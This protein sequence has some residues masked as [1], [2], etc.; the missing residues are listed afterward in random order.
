LRNGPAR[1]RRQQQRAAANQAAIAAE[2]ADAA[3]AFNEEDAEN[4][5][6]AQESKEDPSVAVRAILNQFLLLQQAML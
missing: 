1:Q 6:D 2:A 3:E 4:D 5:M